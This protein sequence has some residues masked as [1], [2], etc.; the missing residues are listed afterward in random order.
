MLYWLLASAPRAAAALPEQPT[1]WW[2]VEKIVHRGHSPSVAETIARMPRTTLMERG[3][4]LSDGHLGDR[5]MLLDWGH[6]WPIEAKPR[7]CCAG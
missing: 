7:R 2:S 6:D 1:A 4:A 5:G 3:G